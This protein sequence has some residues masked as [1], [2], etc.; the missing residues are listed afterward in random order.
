MDGVI[1]YEFCLVQLT[2]LIA[3][4]LLASM[5]FPIAVMQT[6]V[7]LD[8]YAASHEPSPPQTKSYWQAGPWFDLIYRRQRPLQKCAW[9][10]FACPGGEGKKN[11]EVCTNNK[12]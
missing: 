6:L 9:S 1:V 2:F 8:A 12:P 3:P 5:S 7:D 11:Q 4:W 10:K